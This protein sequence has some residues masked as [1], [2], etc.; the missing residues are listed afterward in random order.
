MQHVNHCESINQVS[1]NHLRVVRRYGGKT[2]RRFIAECAC[3]GST[4]RVEY[5]HVLLVKKL[6]KIMLRD[7]KSKHLIEV[8]SLD[9]IDAY[10]AVE[11]LKNHRLIITMA[12]SDGLYMNWRFTLEF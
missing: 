5:E 8:T 1:Y 12:Q 10:R 6:D 7:M 2:M 9:Q 11:D 3:N 4:Q